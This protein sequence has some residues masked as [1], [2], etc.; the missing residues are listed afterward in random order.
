MGTSAY[1]QEPPL[2]PSRLQRVDAPLTGA[3]SDLQIRARLT[4]ADGFIE[5]AAIEETRSRQVKPEVFKAWLAKSN[6]VFSTGISSSSP[7]SIVEVAGRWDHADKT[8]TS[9][10]IPFSHIKSRD[11]SESILSGCKVLVINCAGEIRRD[12]LQLIRDF[13]SRGGYLLSTDWALDNMLSNTFPGTVVW[14]KAV[15]KIDIYDARYVSPDAVLARHTVA[16]SRWKLDESSHLVRILSD[17]VRLLVASSQL[18]LEDPD[19]LGALAVEFPF[20]RGYVL[21]MVGHF[22]NNAKIAIG[23]FLPDSSPDLGI[24][25][26]Q[27]IAANFIVA[28]LTG[29][30]IQ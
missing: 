9:F 22:D 11:L 29:E 17:R 3:V 6:A 21:H 14:N 19:H 30:K 28:G 7:A 13:V 25:L 20:G 16:R 1:A 15:N 27:A 8:L 26:R 12:K 18:A 23:N 24:S 2:A 5:G 10:G 4:P